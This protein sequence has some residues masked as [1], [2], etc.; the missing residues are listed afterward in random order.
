MKVKSQS[1]VAQSCPTTSDPMDCSLPGSSF[2]GIFQ[3]R[4]LEW[5]AIAFS[6]SP[7]RAHLNVHQIS[8]ALGHHWLL[9]SQRKS[10]H[11]EGP[12]S[13]PHSS[14]SYTISHSWISLL[15]QRRSFLSPGLSLV[16]PFG[17]SVSMLSFSTTS[18]H[19]HSSAVF[20]KYASIS[21][22]LIKSKIPDAG[23]LPSQLSPWYFLITSHYLNYIQ[24]ECSL[25]SQSFMN[26]IFT[27]ATNIF[28]SI[29]LA[30]WLVRS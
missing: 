2:H 8:Q 21:P 15:V 14:T 9:V 24:F 23:C 13:T 20:S 7:S 29:F 28:L 27:M 16:P 17:L 5:G 6:D 4:V 26:I 11:W 1:E 3:A 10:G 30:V 18:F 19:K 12:S 25:D 22:F